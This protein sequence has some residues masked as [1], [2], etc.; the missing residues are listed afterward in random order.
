MHGGA[1]SD[2]PRYEVSGLPLVPMDTRRLAG[3]IEQFAEKPF[4]LVFAES[5]NAVGLS[6]H[7]VWPPD[8][9]T[10]WAEK[11]EALADTGISVSSSTASWFPPKRC[12]AKTSRKK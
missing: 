11:L 10:T 2:G 8:V 6:A 7:S 9:G 3:E 4:G 12:S 1:G 5:R